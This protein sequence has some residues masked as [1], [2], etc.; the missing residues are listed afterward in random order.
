MGEVL[1]V[2]ENERISFIWPALVA[3]FLKSEVGSAFRSRAGLPRSAPAVPVG[4][5]GARDLL[6]GLGACTRP[7]ASGSAAVALSTAEFNGPDPRRKVQGARRLVRI[8]KDGRDADE[9]ERF[10]VARQGV[11]VVKGAGSGSRA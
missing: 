9:H 3:I 4:A 7:S 10:G 2:S 6:T 5:G 8:I 1:E 11:L